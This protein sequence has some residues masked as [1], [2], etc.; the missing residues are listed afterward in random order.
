M[1]LRQMRETSAETLET[2][3]ASLDSVDLEPIKLS[4]RV[5]LRSNV[6]LPV[7]LLVELHR[8]YKNDT[9]RANK[10]LSTVLNRHE[11]T[12]RKYIISYAGIRAT[13]EESVIVS[14]MNLNNL[15]MRFAGA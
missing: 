10:L 5:V 1:M 9:A 13:F 4:Q 8:L 15:L 12:D 11:P 7:K 2:L 14:A 6:R 3:P